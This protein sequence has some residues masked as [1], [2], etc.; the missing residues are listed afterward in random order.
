MWR[1]VRNPED[2]FSHNE[3]QFITD[4]SRG[5]TSVVLL[6]VLTVSFGAVFTFYMCR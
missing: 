2:R 1:Q 6:I 4:R 3:V 5:G